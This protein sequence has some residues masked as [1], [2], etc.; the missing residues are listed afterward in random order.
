[1]K[2]IKSNRIGIFCFSSIIGGLF[3]LTDCLF[4]HKSHPDVPWLES[5]AYNPSQVG[6][7]LTVIVVLVGL[8]YLIFGKD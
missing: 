1:M 8:G 5:G 2:P 3:Y 4:A 7:G 6:F